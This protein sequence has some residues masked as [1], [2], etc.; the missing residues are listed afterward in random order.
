VGVVSTSD[1][2]RRGEGAGSRQMSLHVFSDGDKS[3]ASARAPTSRPQP[4]TKPLE[5][6]AG[7]PRL[8]LKPLGGTLRAIGDR[9]VLVSPI[10]TCSAQAQPA[11]KIVPEPDAI[12]Q[13]IATYGAR[14]VFGASSDERGAIRRYRDR[15]S[16]VARSRTT[17]A[18]EA[19]ITQLRKSRGGDAP[20][21]GF[22]ALRIAFGYAGFRLDKGRGA[23]VINGETRPTS[24]STCSGAV[25]SARAIA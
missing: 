23:Y 1:D 12:P 11:P 16:K 22:G 18:R 25:G 3:A 10:L 9:L 8:K 14:V 7:R 21:C 24:R 20:Q 5:S 17:A 6:A 19:L 13:D 15:P 4:S 2:N